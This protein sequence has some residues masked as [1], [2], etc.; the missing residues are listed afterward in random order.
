MEVEPTAA[1][2]A[3]EVISP[4]CPHSL[5][6]PPPDSHTRSGQRHLWKASGTQASKMSLQRSSEKQNET[7]G[8]NRKDVQIVSIACLKLLHQ[9]EAKGFL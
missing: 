7:Y 2:E 9:K 5:S 6:F 8:N 3:V 1:A 4:P